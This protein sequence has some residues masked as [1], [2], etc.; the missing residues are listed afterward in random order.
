MEN[1]FVHTY[2]F[3]VIVIIGYGGYVPEG[4][5]SNFLV[6]MLSF[7][8]LVL[9]SVYSGFLF[10]QFVT[11]YSKVTFSKV[12]TLSNLN[13]FP[14]LQM[15]VGNPDWKTNPLTDVEARLSFQYH[16]KYKGFDGNDT[17]TF[18]IIYTVRRMSAMNRLKS[19]SHVPQTTRK[20]KKISNQGHSIR[21]I[22]C[23]N[24]KGVSSPKQNQS[25]SAS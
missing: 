24:A 7:L 18:N 14:C 3:L 5:F 11:P 17:G 12:I 25:T 19:S 13:G 4:K 8:T 1:E 21:E 16:V 23:Q 15:R 20:K 22:M 6:F 2:I 10:L 9:N